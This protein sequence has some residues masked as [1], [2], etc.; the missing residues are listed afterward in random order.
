MFKLGFKLLILFLPLLFLLAVI[1]YK[2]RLFPVPNNYIVKRAIVDQKIGD[3]QII[4]SGSS[5][6]Y[7]GVK[8]NMLGVPA[9]NIAYFSQDL[10]YDTRILLKILPQAA[11]TKL[12]I[13]PISYF[14]LE[15]KLQKGLESRR[16]NFYRK[17]WDIAPESENFDL[18]RYSSTALF[19]FQSARNYEL[20]GT[21]PK[22]EK[23]GDTGGYEN[24]T[25][26]N[27]YNVKNAK[28]GIDETHLTMTED[29]ITQNVKYLSELF[30]AL[31]VRNIRAVIVTTPCYRTYYE[32]IDSERYDL[33]QNEIQTFSQ[34]YNVE[35]GN[36]LKDE[37]FVIDDF[38]DGSHLN[39]Q[40]AEKFTK[41]IKD[42]IVRKYINSVD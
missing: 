27:L 36:Y 41:I 9:I 13:I 14:S 31:R 3:A 30:E 8:A 5:H 4:I 33:M 22:L 19:G 12:V 37:R 38:Q 29:S 21:P 39:T 23:M 15:Y 1:E 18:A 20:F 26:T 16:V 40:G 34:K 28:A 2:A 6:T 7:Y 10:Y 32:A 42:E 17:F 35:Y 24:E 11:Q 25:F